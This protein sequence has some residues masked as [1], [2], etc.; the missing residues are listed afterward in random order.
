M[1]WHT[2]CYIISPCLVDLFVEAFNCDQSYKLH[3]TT[4]LQH[5]WNAVFKTQKLSACLCAWLRCL[6]LRVPKSM[7]GWLWV[8]PKPQKNQ[9]KNIELVPLIATSNSKLI[10][11]PSFE[12]LGLRSVLQHRDRLKW[13]HKNYGLPGFT[14]WWT[15]MWLRPRISPKIHWSNLG[16]SHDMNIRC[17]T[18]AMFIDFHIKQIKPPIRADFRG[19]IWWF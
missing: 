16:I 4:V 3:Q 11:Q 12:G 9:K 10:F 18:S 13:Y 19:H 14:P 7:A 15:M 8:T 17:V 5:R 2:S 6:S 1:R